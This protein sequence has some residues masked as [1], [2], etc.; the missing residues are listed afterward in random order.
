[1]TRYSARACS[2]WC[3][4]CGGKIAV[5]Y[6]AEEQRDEISCL[7]SECQLVVTAAEAA[8][9]FRRVRGQAR[10]KPKCN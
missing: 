3:I 10:K 2:T 4:R 5:A 1:M 7:D 9:A 8:A 6:N